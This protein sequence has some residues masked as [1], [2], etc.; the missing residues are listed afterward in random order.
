MPWYGVDPVITS[1]QIILALQTIITRQIDSTLTPAVLSIASIHG[2]L[3]N[4]ILPDSVV[5]EGTLRSHDE[6]VRADV[7]KRIAKTASAIAET[8][9]ATATLETGEG[10]PV[11]YNDPALTQWGIQSLGRGVGQ[12]RITE[13]RPVMGAEDFSLLAKVVPGMFF[14][15]GITPPDEDYRSAPANHSPLFHIHE[16]ALK[17]GTRA[18]AYLAI[19]YLRRS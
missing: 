17:Y 8:Q 13:S 6:S 3:R 2:G 10:V 16:P 9:G 12:E 18:L 11:T 19:D 1:A 15:L 5:M 4:N 7:K 14:F